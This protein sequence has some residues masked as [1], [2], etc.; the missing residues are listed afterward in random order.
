MDSVLDCASESKAGWVLTETDW[1]LVE[2]IRKGDTQAFETLYQTQ[3]RRV[4]N[5][6]LRKLGDPTECE[7][8]TQEVFTAVF[9]CID[10]FEGKSD[11]VVWIYGIT[12][13]IVNNRLRRRGGIRLVPLE[14]VPAEASPADLGP[15]PRAEARETLTRVQSAIEDLPKDQK[16]ILELRHGR[17]LAIRKIA[18][19]LDRSEDAIKSSLYRARRTLASKLPEGR[20]QL[21]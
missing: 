4:F 5:F 14:D 12:R 1:T 20:V 18:E 11:L 19:I 13:N 9:T 15:E 16:R 17:R 21:G 10:R 2:A 8:V 7:D 6:A 3:F